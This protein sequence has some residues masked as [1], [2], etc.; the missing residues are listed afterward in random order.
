ME[1]FVFLYNVVYVS[2]LHRLKLKY[3]IS[4][5]W[6]DCIKIVH[7]V[8][9]VIKSLWGAQGQGPTMDLAFYVSGIKIDTYG[10]HA[11]QAQYKL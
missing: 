5:F 6:P 4:R 10:S 7:D 9:I 11:S 8:I 3:V 2:V 1:Y